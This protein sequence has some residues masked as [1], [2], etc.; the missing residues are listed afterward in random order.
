MGFNTTVFLLNDRLDEI[1][2]NPE[3]FVKEVLHAM[4]DGN[5]TD[6]AGAYV[7][8]Q[9]TVM[10]TAHADIHRLYM[11]HGNAMIDLTSPY[12]FE[13]AMK[14]ATPDRRK[15]LRDYYKSQIKIAKSI[16]RD[17]EKDF[18]KQETFEANLKALDGKK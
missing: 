16:L 7:T 3:K 17:W 9:T 13:L 5:D 8:G 10:R 6:R 12:W 14:E 2:R 15:F 18:K 1:Q 11:S 4:H